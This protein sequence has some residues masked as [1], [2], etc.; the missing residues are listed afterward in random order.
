MDLG[1]RLGAPVIKPPKPLT[2]KEASK[3]A[4]AEYNRLKR[5]GTPLKEIAKAKI[6]AL[7]PSLTHDK[8]REI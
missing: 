2:E 4:E 1:E 7:Y 6:K 5:E 3:R 8:R